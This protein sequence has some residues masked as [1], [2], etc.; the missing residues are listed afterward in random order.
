MLLVLGLATILILRCSGDIGL[1]LFN[2]ELTRMLERTMLP[3]ELR[4]WLP[5]DD[6]GIVDAPLLLP[7]AWLVLRMLLR[8]SVTW[9]AGAVAIL[10]ERPPCDPLIDGTLGGRADETPPLIGGFPDDGPVDSFFSEREVDVD[11]PVA[12]S[13]TFV[14]FLKLPE[15]EPVAVATL[16]F[17]FLFPRPPI[18]AEITIFG[19]SP[20]RLDSGVAVN[21][22]S[23]S[24]TFFS[25]SSSPS[26]FI[27]PVAVSL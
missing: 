11:F 24:S 6:F 15:V 14:A 18:S 22:S 17:F 26:T 8:V 21:S 1:F 2:L 7:T 4:V 3:W 10:W 23:S 19:R 5:R 27:F 9:I 16:A 12:A 25:S 20:L 13:E